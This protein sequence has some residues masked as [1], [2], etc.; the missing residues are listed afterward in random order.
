MFSSTLL[1][2]SNV[3]WNVFDWRSENVYSAKISCPV[4]PNMPTNSI[5]K[6]LYLGLN[7]GETQ[8]E[9]EARRVD[10]GS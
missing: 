8:G 2:M 9:T 10:K 7:K 4:R 6:S 3:L 1:L 5:F